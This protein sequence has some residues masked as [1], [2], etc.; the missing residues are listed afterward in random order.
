M[1][2]LKCSRKTFLFSDFGSV[3]HRT[4]FTKIKH[5]ISFRVRNLRSIIKGATYLKVMS[6]Y[7]L[8]VWI[9][10]SEWKKKISFKNQLLNILSYIISLDLMRPFY[11]FQEFFNFAF[12]V[13]R[14]NFFGGKILAL[15]RRKFKVLYR[16]ILEVL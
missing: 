12:Q 6:Y 3:K 7:S 4:W 13:L 8:L 10:T 11:A 5:I 1:L 2:I 15:W 9:W 16:N 14:N